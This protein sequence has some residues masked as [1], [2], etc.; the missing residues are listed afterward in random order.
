MDR[1]WRRSHRLHLSGRCASTWRWC[2]LRI[3]VPVHLIPIIGRRR[4]IILGPITVRPPIMFPR[5]FIIRR[6]FTMHP[7]RPITLHHRS[8]TA[9]VG[10]AGEQRR[11]RGASSDRSRRRMRRRLPASPPR[12][13]PWPPRGGHSSARCSVAATSASLGSCRSSR[14][15]TVA[16][17]IKQQGLAHKLPQKPYRRLHADSGD[18]ERPIRSIALRSC[19]SDR[20]KRMPCWSGRLRRP[21]RRLSPRR[22]KS[23]YYSMRS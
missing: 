15:N 12:R 16:S 13:K 9:Q 2:V 7:R 22:P 23:I 6:Q 8:T 19:L 3:Y 4:C 1:R 5:Q 18:R 21:M 20:P 10:E 11:R 14:W 17:T